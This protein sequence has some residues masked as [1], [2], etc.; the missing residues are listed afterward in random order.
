[1]TVTPI[2]ENPEAVAQDNALA[3]IREGIETLRNQPPA[4]SE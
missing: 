4:P 2:N 3:E 1:M